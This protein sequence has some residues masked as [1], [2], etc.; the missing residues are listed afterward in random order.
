[1]QNE[2]WQEKFY[3]CE[4]LM[5]CQ[6]IEEL[7]IGGYVGVV[8]DILEVV[9]SIIIKWIVVLIQNYDMFDFLCLD[10]VIE[11]SC[12][13]SWDGFKLVML[14]KVLMV[15]KNMIVCV[16]EYE[17]LVVVVIL[18]QDKLLVVWV[19]MVYLLIGFYLLVKILVEVYFDDEQFVVW[20]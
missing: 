18:Q 16:K 17:W 15:Q 8:L 7:D 1:M 14:V 13:L 11:I 2:F 20:W 9:N 12:D 19:L 4:L 5:L 6:F 3:I 10:D